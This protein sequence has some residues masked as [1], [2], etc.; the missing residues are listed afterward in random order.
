MLYSE[1]VNDVLHKLREF[2]NA[3][4]IND[5]GRNRDYL[6]SIPSFLN[7]V[8]REI[9]TT[10]RKIAKVYD[11]AHNMPDNQFG[12]VEWYEE[13]VHD[14][15]DRTFAATG[16][17]AY[18]FQIA[19]TAT[20]YIEEEINSVWTTLITINNT[21]ALSEG[22]TTYK[23]RI[24]GI[25]NPNNSIRIRFSGDYYYPF[26]WVALFTQKYATDAEVP[27][28]EPYVP[29]DLPV[30]FFD[31]D[32]VIAT[33]NER[34][35]VEWSNYRFEQRDSNRKRILINW[36]E[37][38]EFQVHYWS[39]PTELVLDV[40]NLSSNNSYVIEIADEAI[41]AAVSKVAALLM[42]D[43]DLNIHDILMQDFY[44][45]MNNVQQFDNRKNGFQVIQNINNW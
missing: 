26:R 42:V 28:Y 21:F 38:G 4:Q 16:S 44:I 25:T 5:E 2:S 15:E 43:E 35:Y 45:Q 8:Q 32:T 23:G 11:I 7:Q 29:Y 39:Y 33:F 13:E 36:Y 6:L 22:F 19:G 17:N 37:R 30:D 12:R 14:T 31:V 40:D 41:P 3:G 1:F 20:V 10:V 34:Q 18:S 24:T 9:A 27:A